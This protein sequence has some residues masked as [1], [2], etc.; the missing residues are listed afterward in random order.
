MINENIEKLIPAITYIVVL[1][2]FL[3]RA[4]AV[5]FEWRAVRDWIKQKMLRAPIAYLVALLICILYNFDALS[6]IFSESKNNPLF[7]YILTAG[8]IAGGSKGAILLF[9]GVLGFGHKSVSS[10]VNAKS[11]STGNP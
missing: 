8:V 6:V 9:Q 1:S 11:I 7:G 2:I 3:E 5:L 4:L 10:R